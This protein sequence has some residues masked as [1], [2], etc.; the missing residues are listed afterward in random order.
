MYILLI[1]PI[2]L[3]ILLLGSLIRDFNKNKDWTVVKTFQSQGDKPL[4]IIKIQYNHKLND[5][6]IV[7]E[8]IIIDVSLKHEA[9]EYI[10]KIKME[11]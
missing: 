9:E 1:I 11:G 2:A 6:R 4:T 5:Y 8:N 3:I 7:D 10:R